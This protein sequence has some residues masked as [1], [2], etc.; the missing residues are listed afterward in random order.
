M[1]EE[2]VLDKVLDASEVPIGV[3]YTESDELRGGLKGLVKAHY[4]DFKKERRDAAL[5]VFKVL[6]KYS[7]NKGKFH[8]EKMKWYQD[9]IKTLKNEVSAQMVQLG[10]TDW[11]DKM[12]MVL[13][14]IDSLV[15][16]ATKDM[17][18]NLQTS[19]GSAC[20][21]LDDAYGRIIE[22]ISDETDG[23]EV[24]KCREFIEN[25]DRR[26]DIITSDGI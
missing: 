15:E 19:F 3:K 11:V 2:G 10:H 24:E 17:R 5:A 13:G 6:K 1:V 7:K 16:M 25:V 18:K 22:R 12:E 26:I 4:K 8:T 21:E 9:L 23:D 14:E 20:A